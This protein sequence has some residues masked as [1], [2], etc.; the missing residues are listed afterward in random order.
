MRF[1]LHDWPDNKCQ[2]ILKILR[3][4]AGPGS[5]LVVF[6]QIMAHA[7]KYEGPFAEVSNPVKAPSPLLANLGMGIGGFLTMIDL[8]VSCGVGSLYI[9]HLK[10]TKL[11][12]GPTQWEGADST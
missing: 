2:Q 7:C 6:D 1:I 9:L 10:S 3:E 12:A 11:D 5:K 8:Q 4:A